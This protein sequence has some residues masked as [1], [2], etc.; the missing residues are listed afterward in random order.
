MIFWSLFNLTSIDLSLIAFVYQIRDYRVL[1]KFNLF[2]AASQNIL[3][4]INSII[5]RYSRSSQSESDASITRDIKR[6]KFIESLIFSENWM[7][8]RFQLLTNIKRFYNDCVE[9]RIFFDYLNLKNQIHDDITNVSSKDLSDFVEITLDKFF[10]ESRLLRASKFERFVSI[11]SLEFIKFSS[12]ESFIDKNMSR[13]TVSDSSNQSTISV[14]SNEEISWSIFRKEWKT[15]LKSMQI[16]QIALQ[17]TIATINIRESRRSEETTS[18]SSNDNTKWNAEK[19]RF[20]DS[21]Y[22]NKSISIDQVMKHAEKNIYFRD[23]YLFLN[24]V[25]NMTLIHEDQFVRENLFICLRDTALQWY[26]AEI[27]IETKKLLRYEQNLR[28]WTEQFLKRFKKSSD[29]S[30]ITILKERY[31]MKNARRHRKLREYASVI[32]RAAKSTKLGSVANQIAIIYNELNVKFQRNLI[33]SE[34]VTFLNVFL[35][36]I[37]D[38][39]HIWWFL[40]TRSKFNQQ[41]YNRYSANYNQQYSDQITERFMKESTDNRRYENQ[42]SQNENQYSQN[43]SRYRNNYYNSDNYNNSKEKYR[44]YSSDRQSQN[45]YS[46]QFYQKHNYFNRNQSQVYAFALVL[47]QDFSYQSENFY[48]YDK[49]KQNAN[50]SNIQKSSQ[51]S[52][53][54]QSYLQRTFSKS[55][56]SQNQ[57][58]KQKAYYVDEDRENNLTYENEN[59]YNE[60]NYD[61]SDQNIYQADYQDD[62]ESNIMKNEKIED[63]SRNFFVN[64]AK[65]FNSYDCRKC[66]SNFLFK[67]ALHK[68]L[69]TCHVTKKLNI[70]FS[71]IIF[72]NSVFS[73][74]FI[75]NTNIKTWHFFTMSI[76]IDIKF[77]LDELCLNIDCETFMTNRAYIVKMI[78]DYKN[79]IRT[80]TSLKIKE[81]DNAIVSFTEYI[82]V[83]FSFSGNMNEKPAIAKISRNVRIV[84]DLSIK[85]LIDMNI[86]ESKSMIINV[87]TLIIDSCRNLKMNLSATSKKVSVNRVVICASTIV[88]STHISMKISTKLRNKI[89]LSNRD[90]MFHSN[91]FARLESEESIFS[92]IVDS[93][94][95]KI[96][97]INSSNDSVTISRRARL[98]TIK[99]FEKDECYIVSKHDAHL[100]TENWNNNSFKLKI[101]TILAE[102]ESIETEMI[103]ETKIIIFD[104]TDAQKTIQQMIEVYFNLWSDDKRA[105]MNI[106][107]SDWMSINILSD[108]KI[109]FAK[110]YSV[111]SKDKKLINE[112]FDKLHAQERMKYSKQ[113]TSY[114][115]FVF[116]VW[117][118]ILKSD[119]KSIR[120]NRVVVDIRDFNKI[121]ESDNYFMSLQF[122]II[123]VVAECKYISVFDA[124]TFFY[125]WNVRVENRFKFTVISHREQEQFN[126]V[127]MS[128]KE[129]STYVQRQIDV[130]LRNHRDYSRVFIDDIVVYSQTLEDHVK[131]FHVIF[132][133]L[134]SKNISLNSIKSFLDYFSIQLLE[135]KVDVFELITVVEKIETIA[136]LKFSKTLKDFEIYLNF[137]EWLR[138]Y[139]SYFAQKSNVLQLRKTNLIRQISSNKD[140]SRKTYAARISLYDVTIA[141]LDSYEQIQKTFSR[142]NF[143]F[144]FSSTKVLYI[145]MNVFKSY[146]FDAMIYHTAV[147]YEN[148]AVISQIDVQSIMFLSKMLIAV[149]TRY[150]STK[151]EVATLI[152]VI[153]K[154]KHMIETVTKTTVIFI[155]HFA[156]TSIVRQTTLSFENTDKLNLKLVRAFVY[157]FQFDLDVRYKFDKTNIVFDALFRLFTINSTKLS[158]KSCMRRSLQ[159]FSAK[160]CMWKKSFQISLIIMTNDFKKKFVSG[161]AADAFWIKIIKTIKNFRKRLEAETKISE[162]TRSK[163]R[164]KYENNRHTNMNFVLRNDLIYHEER[165]RLCISSSLDKEI[166]DLTHN[167]NQYFEINRCYARI[168]ESLYV[169]HLSKKLRQYISHC[170]ECQL[171]QIRR[172]KAYEELLSIK[173]SAILFHTISIDFIMTISEEMNTLLTIICKFF[174][175]VIILT[176]QTIFSAS[177]WVDFVLKRLQIADWDISAAIISNR[178]SKFLSKFWRTLFKRLRVALLT[179]TTYHAQTDDQS[180]RTNQTMKIAIRF[181]IT[182]NI[183]IV[184][185]LSFLQAQ[186]NNSSNVSID[187]SSNDIV[188]EFKVREALFLNSSNMFDEDMSNLRLRNRQKIADAIS[189]ANAHMKIRY[190]FRHKLLLFRAE[191]KAYLRLHKNY[192]IQEQHKKLNN[193]RCGSFLIKRRVDRLAYELNISHRWKIHSVIS[194]AQLESVLFVQ[195]SY[196][197]SRS[198]HSESIYVEED[199]E[200]EK[201][202]EIEAIID[203]RIRKFEKTSIT[204]YKIKWLR[205]D[206]E[207]DEWRFVAKLDDCMNLVKNYEKQFTSSIQ[208]ERWSF[209]ER[210]ALVTCISWTSW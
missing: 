159:M 136:K 173:S 40:A 14:S 96:V 49:E 130:I 157:L 74:E 192:A 100:A 4:L 82:I 2:Q 66:A 109:P 8:D 169:S 163:N 189:F 73:I 127:V 115:Y 129:S 68:H 23:V 98:D 51:I 15:M 90:Y 104:I 83:N 88:I 210:W 166:F 133:L 87:N 86:I 139:V 106:S 179:S 118:T 205:Y 42:Y 117:Q 111:E 47:Q 20:F 144:H 91:H 97:V 145:D 103:T 126:V 48:Q 1:I 76:N 3:V 31:I 151:F 186:L 28:Y 201:S 30:I 101:Q 180:K 63:I 84:N 176:D 5:T 71:Q 135:Q 208:R 194:V 44:V 196:N 170:S 147:S 102:N 195:N 141:K 193:Q 25:K 9:Y 16:M 79:K 171:N 85:I 105:T 55:S 50:A 182:A 41:F 174:K 92:H 116:V 54:V 60:D 162:I 7:I 52:S 152:W 148:L 57:D 150:W 140:I 156:S 110:I 64:S 67:N 78:S 22:D 45:L 26:T 107:K 37:D 138:H 89:S 56:M 183:D 43:Q 158:T 13:S 19:L 172:H 33:R 18:N 112:M 181:L 185:T 177:Q 65:K 94:F 17:A 120:K 10:L 149:E 123:F 75:I 168:S 35:R 137:I 155:D 146:E 143:L 128:F 187:F 108:A 142:Q 175:R 207:F 132:D 62:Y 77:T 53:L 113:S 12:F 200:F 134:N 154:I 161:Y 119:Q 29:V 38:F 80:T 203:K 93:G 188:Y 197:R 99:K 204:Q 70:S 121:V 184:S 6:S 81:I 167:K 206:S 199:N 160:S 209:F 59:A 32:L 24:R 122:D 36:K 198:E 72:S 114:D 190:D 191:N 21:M 58:M 165:Q 125:Q 39:K 153:K 27:S 178:D 11:D 124:A 69:K 164:S 61:E 202:Y 95:F 46:N 34:N 131:H